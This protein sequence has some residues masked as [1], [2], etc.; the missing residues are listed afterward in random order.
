M[1]L[2]GPGAKKRQSDI[3]SKEKPR[4]VLPW[5]A[6]NL[7]RVERV[8]A[9]LED[10]PITA[11]TLAGSKM[12]IRD[13][14]RSYIEAIYATDETGHREVVT[15]I[16]S[17]ARKNG[18]TG[19]VA[20]LVLCHMM[21]PEA[22]PRGEVYA[23]ANDR[24]QA[25]KIFSEVAAI[26]GQHLELG[27]RVNIKRFNKEIEVLEGEGAGTVFAALS[28]EASTKLGLSPSFV[29][30]DEYG[31]APN[32]EL[33]DALNTAMGARD[34][35]LMCVISTQAADDIHPFSQLIDY[36]LKLQRG[37]VDP[38]P[39]FHLT[40]FTAPE[41][42][43]P[44]AYDTWL[45]ANPALGDFRSLKDV[46]RQAVQA[47][48]MP[49]KE[50]DFRNKILNQRIAAHVRF[51]AKAEWDACGGDVDESELVG[52]KCYG[53]LDLSQAR[54]LTAWILVFPEID[55]RTVV[56]PRFFLPESG[57]EEKSH[58]DRVPYPLWVKEGHLIALPGKTIDP[59]MIAQVMARDAMQFDIQAV[60]FDR[61]RIEDLRR[62]LAEI[63]CELPLVELGQGYKDMSPCVSALERQIAEVELLHG[64]NP[65]L[66]MCISNAI[67]TMDPAGARKLD[68][69]KASGRIDGAVALAMALRTAESDAEEE[70]ELPA[71]L[72]EDA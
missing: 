52:R 43:D 20:G 39:T 33:Y 38:D 17:L 23:A 71:W 41:D 68:K 72:S 29:V 34:E 2:R 65:V 12:K 21:G 69:S 9:F 57:L 24:F 4:K 14:Q 13:W 3:M 35:P 19:L 59:A 8:I 56:L 27:E 55:G 62:E 16:L 32:S 31:Y 26:L 46:E 10:L 30:V 7:S 37:E 50:Q 28:S 42:A 49:S 61:W 70:Y 15:A 53:G 60:G 36:G 47:K 11:G 66:T 6:E 25:G 40:L 18:K 64:R 45:L 1:G 5:Q 48:L 63:G 58:A 51:V 54:D 22:I 44:W 67:V